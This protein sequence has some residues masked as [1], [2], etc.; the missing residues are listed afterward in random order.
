MTFSAMKPHKHEQAKDRC[1]LCGAKWPCA[2]SQYESVGVQTDSS[3]DLPEN[4][5]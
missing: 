5:I 1:I 4:K 3:E 2:M